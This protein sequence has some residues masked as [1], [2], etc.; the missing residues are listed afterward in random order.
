MNLR[1]CEGVEKYS[2]STLN[3]YYLQD[4]AVERIKGQLP[5][6]IRI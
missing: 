4:W 2:K 1:K 6:E 5:E 3:T